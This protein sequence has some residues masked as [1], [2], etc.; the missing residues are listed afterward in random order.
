MTDARSLCQ[1]LTEKM[2]IES[3]ARLV[4]VPE[5]LTDDAD[6][7][8]AFSISRPRV[9]EVKVVIRFNGEWIT[10]KLILAG[11]TFYMYIKEK[12]S[13]WLRELGLTQLDSV[14]EFAV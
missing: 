13:K 14:P 12:L 1:G 9:D 5:F 2:A 10:A 11:S 4:G 7:D 8:N 3:A 6:G